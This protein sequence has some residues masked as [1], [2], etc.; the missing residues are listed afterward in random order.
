MSRLSDL[1]REAGTEI[2]GQ[3]DATSQLLLGMVKQPVAGLTGMSSGITSLLRGK[4]VDQSLADAVDQIERVNA[5]G[6]PVTERGQQRLGELGETMQGVTE[7]VGS[8][9]GNPIDKLGEKSPLLG[10]AALGLV[11]T[12]DPT[13]AIRAGKTALRATNVARHTK[14]VVT[15]KVEPITFD[16]N[17][18]EGVA[19]F[20]AREGRLPVHLMDEATRVQHFGPGAAETPVV[21]FS[22]LKS[23]RELH[24]PGGLGPDAPPMTLADQAKI[25][26]QGIDYNT[27]HP[28]NALAIH[29]RLV[30]SV[31]PGANPSDL[32]MM[33]RLGFGVTSGNAP[34]TKNLIEWAQMRPRSKGEMAEWADYSPVGI[35]ESMP[36]PEA[37]NALN[38]SINE[39]YG[40]Q[41]GE[42]GGTGVANTANRQY[43]SDLAAMLREEPDFFRKQPGEPD[44]QYVERLINQVRGL[45]PK[46]GS[47]GFAMVE[48][49]T[50]NISAI[51]RHI[52][53]LTREKVSNAPATADLYEQ[54]MLNAYNRD[55]PPEARTPEIGLARIEAGEAGPDIEA[56]HF[57]DIVS[58]PQT[59][60]YKDA[61]T[62]QPRAD[63]PKHLRD[64]P[65]YE[66]KQSAEIGPIYNEALK[67][68][69]EGGKPRGI[70]GFSNQWHDWDFQRSRAEPHAGMNP[71]ATEMERLTPEEYKQVRDTFSGAGAMRTAKEPDT[72]RLRGLSPTD[73]WRKLLYWTAPGALTTGALV[74]AL[75]E[76]EPEGF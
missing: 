50:T 71:M 2:G 52:A 39:A 75:R 45:G 20:Q 3:A 26:A 13:K 36:S 24:I 6:G 56:S 42:R 62:G 27:L 68:I 28:E 67:Q 15:P 35:G 29:K 64:L 72:G 33:N 74:D 73:D 14:G 10:A 4:G 11:E 7:K 47:L 1:L 61:R 43:V 19:A 69:E 41:A 65:F 23:R 5:W 18:P 59:R 17:T 51:D 55:K 25:S 21:P 63:L 53:D 40:V 57:R 16:I 58:S 48:P 66:P 38:R 9:L 32:E 34:I 60:M 54:Q 49:Q 70:G 31:D 46:T 37:A 22:D 12:A 8:A 76:K 44:S 30:Q